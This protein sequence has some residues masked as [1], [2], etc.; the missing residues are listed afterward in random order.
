MT[1]TVYKVVKLVYHT[2]QHGVGRQR[3]SSST[4]HPQF[5]TVYPVAEW[6]TLPVGL[7]FVFVDENAAR[8]YYCGQ[9]DITDRVELWLCQSEDVPQQLPAMAR[10]WSQ[11][12]TFW[13]AHAM[14]DIPT[15]AKI[16]MACSPYV[17]G[18]KTL[19]LFSRLD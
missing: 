15:L 9:Q 3:I 17:Y 13:E 10:H 19:R 8:D 7:S 12:P 4:R 11:V 6:L 1:H 5:T 18:V 14:K 16:I 2:P